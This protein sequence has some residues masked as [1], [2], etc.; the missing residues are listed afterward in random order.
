MRRVD[1]SA[2]VEGM[3]GQFGPLVGGCDMSQML[4]GGQS[5]DMHLDFTITG[6]NEPVKTPQP[7]A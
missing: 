4:D 3:F 2:M 5:A 7:R 6:V 1:T